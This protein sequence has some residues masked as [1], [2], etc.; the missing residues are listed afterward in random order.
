MRR[1]FVSCVALSLIGLSTAKAVEPSLD[2]KEIAV[3]EQGE[4]DLLAAEINNLRKKRDANQEKAEELREQGASLKRQNRI[5]ARM[6][7][8]KARHHEK[9]MDSAERQV[10]ELQK[11]MNEVKGAG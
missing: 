4:F 10:K 8:Q 3:V 7:M 5:R 6:F 1:L 9:V 2:T 11:R